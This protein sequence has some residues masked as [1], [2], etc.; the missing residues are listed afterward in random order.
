M[1]L[2]QMLTTG[3]AAYYCCSVKRPTRYLT[4]VSQATAGVI[5]SATAGVIVSQATAGVI[6]RP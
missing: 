5:V 1:P 4:R 6:G 2:P 3:G